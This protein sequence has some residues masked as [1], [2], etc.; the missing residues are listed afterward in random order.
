MQMPQ[1]DGAELGTLVQADASVKDTRMVMFTSQCRRGDARRM[2]EIGFSGYLSKLLHQSDLY[3]A[4]LQVSGIDEVAASVA[5]VTRYTAAEHVKTRGRVL[6]VEDNRTNQVVAK[7]MLTKCGVTVTLAANGEEAPSALETLPFDI[8]FMDCQM[9]VMDGYDATRAI[10]APDTK[11]ARR[12]I[13]VI[14][15]TAKA[16]K[17]DRERCLDARMDDYITKPVDRKKL[18]RALDKWL[19]DARAELTES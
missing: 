7:G 16:M 3:N 15:M 2:K 12:D 1:M 5:L 9:P 13:P 6:V 8:V 17:G 11:V 14:A 18:R 19:P 4:L 10:R